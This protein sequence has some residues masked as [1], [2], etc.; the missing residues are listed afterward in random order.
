[1]GT[2]GLQV[3]GKTYK[4]EGDLWLPKALS[5]FSVACLAT[6]GYN[7]GHRSGLL[8]ARQRMQQPRYCASRNGQKTVRR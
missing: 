4:A 8:A 3:R 6:A 2:N 5:G 1:M 7:G